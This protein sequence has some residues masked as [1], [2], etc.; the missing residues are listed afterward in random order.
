MTPFISV[1]GV[2]ICITHVPIIHHSYH[3]SM[4]VIGKACRYKTKECKMV[5]ERLHGSKCRF[6]FGLY[7]VLRH[8]TGV[9]KTWNEVNVR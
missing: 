5:A 9:V 8:S 6:V 1:H 2:L 7:R 4:L 3:T